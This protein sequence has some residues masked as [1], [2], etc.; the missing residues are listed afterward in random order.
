M[1]R[2]GRIIVLFARR[3]YPARGGRGILSVVSDDLGETWSEEFVL[4]GDAYTWDC[5]YPVMIELEDG[6]FFAA[7]YFT[8]KDGDVPVPE[9]A[10]VRHIVG[11]FFQLD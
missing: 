7:Y 5:G 9:Y 8:S 2:N 6:R 11:T 3:E 4:R 1:P 10:V